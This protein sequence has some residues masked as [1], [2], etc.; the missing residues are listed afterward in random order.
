MWNRPSTSD[1]LTAGYGQA[2]VDAGGDVGTARMSFDA[3]DVS[4]S[5][6]FTPA[7]R[8]TFPNT[9]QLDLAGLIGRANS[10]SYVPKSTAAS[11]RLRSL[12]TDL[13]DR[14]ADRDGLVTMCYETEV[15]LAHRM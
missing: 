7:V 3:D 15:F 2:I 8:T 9:Q 11:A 13:H 6:V 5:G 12:L 14:Y 1:A 4:R 10:A